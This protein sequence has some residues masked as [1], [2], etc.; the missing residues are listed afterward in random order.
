M[1]RFEA[2]Y[3]EM[4]LERDSN[5]LRVFVIVGLVLMLGAAV[6]FILA[7]SE[8]DAIIHV[9]V[10]MAMVAGGLFALRASEARIER[11]YSRARS[12]LPAIIF[13]RRGVWVHERTG[14][15]PIPWGAVSEVEEIGKGKNSGLRVH[16]YQK[17]GRTKKPVVIPAE[18]YTTNIGDIAD[19]LNE[20]RDIFDR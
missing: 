12:G 1:E 10:F 2:H 8:L 15:N 19:A 18:L 11:F 7:L 13:D 3:D 4:T 14:A 5:S 16:T 17:P 6:L 9:A 20:F